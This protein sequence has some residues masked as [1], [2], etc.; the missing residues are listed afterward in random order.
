MCLCTTDFVAAPI[1]GHQARAILRKAVPGTDIMSSSGRKRDDTREEASGAFSLDSVALRYFYSNGHQHNQSTSHTSQSL[2]LRPMTLWRR[3]WRRV[4]IATVM[5]LCEKQ[6]L[7]CRHPGQGSGVNRDILPLALQ[8]NLGL[9]VD[10]FQFSMRIL[11]QWHSGSHPSIQGQH[12]RLSFPTDRA[13][14]GTF[15]TSLY[16]PSAR[17]IMR[18]LDRAS[19]NVIA[20]ALLVVFSLPVGPTPS[21]FRQSY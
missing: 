2:E 5:P 17:W 15:N 16:T 19:E 10:L 1:R 13:P 9:P 6:K 18:A 3:P 12:A 20:P 7:S 11:N 4:I 8:Y 14:Y 21:F